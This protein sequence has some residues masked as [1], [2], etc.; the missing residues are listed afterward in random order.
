MISTKWFQGTNNL[1][2]VLEIRKKVFGEELNKSEDN[3]FDIY[4]DFAFS[5]VIFED[6][7]PVGTGRL[8]FKDGKYIVDMLCVL[9]KFRGNNYGD[10]IVRMLVRKAI[11]MGAENTYATINE[12]CKQLF[13]NIG[14]EKITTY[15]NGELLMLK[16]G[17]VG[18]NCC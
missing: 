9:K 15:E 8:L 14:F 12:N 18:G 6:D 5:A 10:L 3:V 16:I 7:L 2:I 11:N 17:D 4:D 1:E 13:E